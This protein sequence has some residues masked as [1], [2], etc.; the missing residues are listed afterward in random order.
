MDLLISSPSTCKIGHSILH[1]IPLTSTH[2]QC[3]FLHTSRKEKYHFSTLSS[4]SMDTSTSPEIVGDYSPFLRIYKDGRIERLKGTDVVPPSLDDPNSSVLSK[5]VVY[6]PEENLV[7]RLYLP[8]NIDPNKKI[9]LLVYFHGG[10]FCIDT[11]FSANYH[12]YVYSLVS[13]AKVV[14]VSVDYRR[15]PEH[16]LPIAYD[17][18][19]TAL[20]WVASHVNEDGPEQWLN[21][22]TDLG[23]VFLAG[24]SAGAN[25][26][27]QIALRCGQQKL[28]GINVAGAVL[29]HPYFW[30]KEPIGEEAQEV[31]VRR[32][33]SAVWYFACPTTSGC[34][35]PLINPV[36]DPNLASLGCSRVLVIVAEKD[37]LRDRGWLYY[38][39]LKKSGWNGEVEIMEAKEE[40]HVF[41]LE[42]FACENAVAMLKRIASFFNEAQA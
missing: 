1:S 9:P 42:N 31:E 14:A 28:Q 24:D 7:S 26:A 6:S 27:H 30:G 22:H 12:N 36:V 17:D 19:W 38:D 35:D 21:V 25:I 39:E 11:P 33:I 32:T 8:K 2:R 37:M 40:N 23:K 4:L 3:H 20:N 13:E 16:P 18:S 34:D 29:I 15:A 10:G 5:D 41:H